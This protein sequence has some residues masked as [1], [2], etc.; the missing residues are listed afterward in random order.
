VILPNVKRNISDQMA[1]ALIMMMG[2]L[3]KKQN[4]NQKPTMA[5]G[6]LITIQNSFHV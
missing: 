4:R 1:M 2:M 6:T 3:S 5:V